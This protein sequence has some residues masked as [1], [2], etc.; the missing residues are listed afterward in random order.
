MEQ[1]DHQTRQ[2]EQQNGAGAS[3]DTKIDSFSELSKIKSYKWQRE[4]KHTSS[5][6]PRHSQHRQCGRCGMKNHTSNNCKITKRKKCMKCC[7]L[8]HFA[9]YRKT[10]SPKR[11]ETHEVRA[12]EIQ[13]ESSSDEE[14]FLLKIGNNNRPVYP[15]CVEDAIINM[16]IDSGSTLNIID[17]TT[18]WKLRTMP[19]LQNSTDK[20]FTYSGQTPLKLKGTFDATVKAFERETKA[21]IYVTE[22]SNGAILGQETAEKLNILRVG[23]PE[24]LT[25]LSIN[26]IK[27]D[28]HIEQTT[29]PKIQQ[30]LDNH[31]RV[32]QCMGKLKVCQLQ[33]HIDKNVAPVQQ[34][35]R[36]LP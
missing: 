6:R 15:I 18:Y 14:S 22:G 24:D 27:Q 8:G 9:N 3:A 25:H 28:K 33:L 12:N 13:K 29:H 34:T 16:L 36:R 35:I 26:M 31:T 11:A 2:I 17:E 30:I 21:K 7:I 10:R 19:K 1:S 23:P 32:F 20:I 5:G 4:S